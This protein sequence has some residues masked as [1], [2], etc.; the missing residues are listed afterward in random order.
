MVVSDDSIT[1]RQAKQVVRWKMWEEVD[2][3]EREMDA[4]LHSVMPHQCIWIELQTGS[5]NNNNNND[6]ALLDNQSSLDKT[7]YFVVTR[8]VCHKSETHQCTILLL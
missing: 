3:E 7:S 4:C 2:N 6:D 5:N 1:G 8:K